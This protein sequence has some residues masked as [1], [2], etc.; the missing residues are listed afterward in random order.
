MLFVIS[1]H[2]KYKN[3][4]ILRLYYIKSGDVMPRVLA[5]KIIRDVILIFNETYSDTRA[6]NLEHVDCVLLSIMYC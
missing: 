4:N 5:D 2:V 3:N 6:I 1:P